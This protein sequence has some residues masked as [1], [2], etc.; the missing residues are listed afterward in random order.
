LSSGVVSVK[1]VSKNAVK[2][3]GDPEEMEDDESDSSNEAEY[4]FYDNMDTLSDGYNYIRHP[5]TPVPPQTA[6][7]EEVSPIQMSLIYRRWSW[8]LQQCR[9][10]E[11]SNWEKRITLS[12][13]R[14]E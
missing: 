4:D 6:S 2:G 8:T 7:D 9:I 10:S 3:D 5:S 13:S 12:P 1:E 14:A 11:R